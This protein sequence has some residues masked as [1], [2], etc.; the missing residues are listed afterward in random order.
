MRFIKQI[1]WA[2]LLVTYGILFSEEYLWGP[3]Q[4]IRFTL[5]TIHYGTIP[6]LYL[7]YLINGIQ[8]NRKDRND[9]IRF[10]IV[11]HIRNVLLFI[12][13]WI[14]TSIAITLTVLYIEAEINRSKHRAED[15]ST[16]N[17]TANIK[18]NVWEP[19][20]SP[21]G[22]DLTSEVATERTVFLLSRQR[23]WFSP[24]APQSDRR[25]GSS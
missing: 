23:F 4:S 10:L 24:K 11:Y 3:N 8:L 16:Q 20:S 9:L 21:A 2:I 22:W 7:T 13:G 5:G 25:A 17:V 15:V 6:F 19:L 1:L 14:V 18:E 12:V